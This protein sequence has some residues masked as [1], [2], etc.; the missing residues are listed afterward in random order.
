M[1]KISILALCVA[2]AAAATAQKSVIKEAE[3]AM[4]SG[5]PFAEVV[6]IVTPAFTN[7]ETE[8]AAITYY[9]PGKAG[10]KEYDDVLGKKQVG[11][12]K[13][14]DPK[15][16]SAANALLGG[17]EYYVKTLP[18]DS[19]PDE[20]GK[21]KP[22]YS[23]EI[24]S[25]IAGHQADFNMAAV[26]FWNEKEYKKAAQSWQIFLDLPTDPLF[27]KAKFQNFPDSVMSE[28]AFNQGLA[29][30]QA[31]DLAGAINAFRNA[32]KK[33]YSKKPVYEYGIAVATGA[34]D[35]EALLE[36]ASAGNNLYGH[37]DPQFI[38]QIVNYYLQTEKYDEA[39]Q[40]LADAV[41]ADADNSQYYA[42]EG[43]IYDNKKDRAKAMELYQKALDLD[44]DNAIALFYM[45]RAYAAKAGDLSD[46][47]NGTNFD[48]FKQKELV[49]LYQKA[50]DYLEKAYKLDPN[51]RTQILQVLEIAYYNLD[52]KN[53]YDSVQ[54]RK[55]DD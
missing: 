53:G 36:F 13:Q 40:F 39:L 32:I 55:L 24:L 20:K 30:W 9:I 19:L 11:L 21:V 2:T 26:D 46:E 29:A 37:S 3:S 42:L 33:G 47:Y 7:P 41:A 51:N 52:D 49:P 25:T 10:F 28:I 14:D 54:Q 8:K 15:V 27:A 35:N 23:K 43:I 1:K 31:E 34:K 48:S 12:I 45:G 22:R 17:Y 44:A 6:T 4:K 5:K 38:N 50:V 16:L 18:L